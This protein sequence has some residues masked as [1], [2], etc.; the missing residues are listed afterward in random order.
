MGFLVF[1]ILLLP[2]ILLYAAVQA[3]I[4]P[5]AGVLAPVLALLNDPVFV[6]WM[7]RVLLVWN[8]LVSAALVL[9]R[10]SMK[11]TRGPNWKWEY[12]H[13]VLGW[14]RLGRRLVCL[15]L[16]LGLWWEIVLV[17]IFTVLIAFSSFFF[18]F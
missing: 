9:V 18:R 14:R 12:I 4:S 7:L 17:L 5:F 1:T 6:Y 16:T 3:L 11:R 15:V 8:I 2:A 13:A 10:R